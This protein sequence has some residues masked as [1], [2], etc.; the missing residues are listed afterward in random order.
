MEY[1]SF[2]KIIDINF[3][4]FAIFNPLRTFLLLPEVVNPIAISPGWPIASICL[5]KISLKEKSFPI[6]V[7]AEVSEIGRA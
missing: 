3:F 2:V 7:K 6:A 5:E 1:F 4:F